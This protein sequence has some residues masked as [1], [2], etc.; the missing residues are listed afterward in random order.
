MNDWKEEWKNIGK[1]LLTVLGLII[2]FFWMF[3]GVI[4]ILGVVE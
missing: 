3:A 2:L 4:F 1:G